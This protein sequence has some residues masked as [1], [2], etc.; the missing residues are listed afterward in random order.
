MLLPYNPRLL[1][2]VLTRMYIFGQDRPEGDL[3]LV[4]ARRGCF[5]DV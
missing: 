5:L 2:R 1:N 4:L 3:C